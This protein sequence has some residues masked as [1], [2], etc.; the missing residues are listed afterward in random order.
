MP[1]KGGGGSYISGEGRKEEPTLG[2]VLFNRRMKLEEET[3]ASEEGRLL[4]EKE[5]KELQKAREARKEAREQLK[6]HEQEL[7][8]SRREVLD[9][10]KED[11]EENK[12]IMKELLLKE[13]E[14]NRGKVDPVVLRRMI[15][16]ERALREQKEQNI[17]EAGKKLEGAIKDLFFLKDAK[18]KQQ[19]VLG[20]KKKTAEQPKEADNPYELPSDDYGKEIVRFETDY[21]NLNTKLVS[22]GSDQQAVLWVWQEWAASF[23][24]VN[25]ALTEV[26]KKVS[27][28]DP[29]ALKL[30]RMALWLFKV[31]HE[32]SAE[33][34]ITKEGVL[35]EGYRL[36]Q[37][38]PDILNALRVRLNEGGLL[39]TGETARTPAQNRARTA[40]AAPSFAGERRGVAWKPAGAVVTTQGKVMENA[41][42]QEKGFQ[43]EKIDHDIFDEWRDVQRK[44]TK[45]QILPLLKKT[46]QRFNVVLAAEPRHAAEWVDEARTLYDQAIDPN[47][48]QR[49]FVRGKVSTVREHRAW[50]LHTFLQSADA[51]LKEQKPIPED[52]T[53][54]KIAPDIAKLSQ[55]ADATGVVN[56]KFAETAKFSDPTAAGAPAAST[57]GNEHT[58]T[59]AT[60]GRADRK[61][62]ESAAFSFWE[63]NQQGDIGKNLK[64][65]IDTIDRLRNKQNSARKALE[66][67]TE[68]KDIQKGFLGRWSAA[69]DAASREALT[70]KQRALFVVLTVAENALREN[71]SIT[72]DAVQNGLSAWGK[73]R[74][75]KQAEP[76]GTTSE[77]AAEFLPEEPAREA[78]TLPVKE[79]YSVGE[80]SV[81][82]EK[83][84]VNQDASYADA[85]ARVIAVFDG[86][87]GH[88]AGEMASSEAKRELQECAAAL[89]GADTVERAH[90]LLRDI[91]IAMNQKV[92]DA[93]LGKRG[94]EKGGTTAT[95][96]KV[97]HEGDKRVAVVGNLG[98]SRAY[99]FRAQTHQLEQITVDDDLLG[100]L[101]IQ[102]TLTPYISDIRRILSQ[103][104]NEDQLT[105]PQKFAE[106][107]ADMPIAR[108]PEGLARL[109]M[110]IKENFNLISPF[111][112]TLHALFDARN[113]I[114]KALNGHDEAPM[115]TTTE[116]A[117]GDFILCTSDGIHDNLTADSMRNVIEEH[118]NES[119]EQIARVLIDHAQECANE[120]YLR[121]KKDDMTVVILK[122]E[123]VKIVKQDDG[124]QSVSTRRESSEPAGAPVEA[125]ALSVSGEQADEIEALPVYKELLTLYNM[126]RDS[127]AARQSLLGEWR[128]AVSAAQVETDRVKALKYILYKINTGAFDT[129]SSEGGGV[130]VRAHDALYH[131]LHDL[132]PDTAARA[133]IKAG[134]QFNVAIIGTE[135]FKKAEI[136]EYN[137]RTIEIRFS[138]AKGVVPRQL[139]IG[140][141]YHISIVQTNQS[142]EQKRGGGT[143]YWHEAEVVGPNLAQGDIFE[144][145]FERPVNPGVYRA[146]A[147]DGLPVFVKRSED[148]DISKKYNVTITSAANFLEDFGAKRQH[149]GVIEVSETFAGASA[150]SARAVG[151]AEVAHAVV[152]VLDLW[153]GLTPEKKAE[154]AADRVLFMQ[155]FPE[156]IVTRGIF[157]RDEETKE[158]Q[159]LPKGN[160]D[161]ESC[162]FLL[163]HFFDLPGE[164]IEKTKFV[165]PG[166]FRPN[167]L[168]VDTGFETT[169]FQVKWFTKD[170]LSEQGLTVPEML[171]Q[172]EED[173]GGAHV[174]IVQDHGPD[175]NRTM[176][177]FK[178]LYDA[179]IDRYGD[180]AIPPEDR[181][182]MK[183]FV[184]FVTHIDNFTAPTGDF[185][186]KKAW[187]ESDKIPFTITLAK[188]N[189]LN[190]GA[191]YQFFKDHPFED[192]FKR[193]SEWAINAP[194]K[195]TNGRYNFRAETAALERYGF[196]AMGR[197]RKDGR[198]EPIMMEQY[199]LIEKGNRYFE[200]LLHNEPEFIVESSRYG[201][202]L[203]VLDGDN[204]PGRLSS[205]MAHGIDGMLE[206]RPGAKSF[207]FNVAPQKDPAEYGTPQIPRE[208]A[209]E[210]GGV[211]VR[212]SIVMQPDWKKQD[213]KAGLN[214]GAFLEKIGVASDTLGVR[215]RARVVEEN[216]GEKPWE[217]VPADADFLALRE[218]LKKEISNVF[219]QGVSTVDPNQK[220]VNG[221]KEEYFLRRFKR[222]EKFINYSI[223]VW[224]SAVHE[225]FNDQIM[226]E[227]TKWLDGYMKVA[228]VDA[229]AGTITESDGMVSDKTQFFE[230]YKA[231]PQIYSSAPRGLWKGAV[232]RWFD[233]V[234]AGE[235]VLAAPT[236]KSEEAV[237]VAPAEPMAAEPVTGGENAPKAVEPAGAP[238][239]EDSAAGMM[240]RGAED[241]AQ[242]A[243]T[244]E[245]ARAI[246]GAEVE[247]DARVAEARAEL[248]RVTERLARARTAKEQ[249]EGIVKGLAG[250]ITGKGSQAEAEYEA[251]LGAYQEVTER[252]I[253]RTLEQ[254]LEWRV[255]L[256]EKM[257]EARLATP[258]KKG[259]GARAVALWKSA[260]E[261]S[262]YNYIDKKGGW[263][264]K[265]GFVW[266]TLKILSKAANLRTATAL[267]LF[268][269]GWIAG[270][271]AVGWTAAGAGAGLSALGSGIG[272][273]EWTR[274][275]YE[276]G[277]GAVLFGKKSASAVA[278][279]KMFK[280]QAEAEAYY[281]T[282]YAGAGRF[283]KLWRG[284]SGQ[285][286]S[287]EGAAA[288]AVW[289]E[290]L[291]KGNIMD[292]RKA[293]A[294][295]MLAFE[296]DAVLHGKKDLGSNAAYQTLVEAYKEAVVEEEQKVGGALEGYFEAQGKGFVEKLDDAIGGEKSALRRR[297]IF[298]AFAGA[299]LGVA[300]L[301]NFDVR[302]Y[303]RGLGNNGKPPGES[304][305]G[306]D[307]LSG[308]ES[309]PLPRTSSV[310]SVGSTPTTRSPFADLIRGEQ[311]ARVWTGVHKV[312]DGK[313]AH[314]VPQKGHRAVIQAVKELLKADPKEFGM[315]THPSDALVE[316]KATAIARKLGFMGHGYSLGFKFDAEHPVGL[317]AKDGQ[318]SVVA[319]DEATLHNLM[320][321]V[322]AGGGV[323]KPDAASPYV[324]GAFPKI[325][326]HAIFVEGQSGHPVDATHVQASAVVGQLGA[327]SGV[328]DTA[329]SAPRGGDIG[330]SPVGGVGARAHVV[331]GAGVP[332]GAGLTAGELAPH[333]GA[334]AGRG[335]VRAG[336]TVGTTRGVGETVQ[337]AR[338]GGSVG[339]RTGGAGGG[340]SYET[341]TGAGGGASYETRTGAGGG[342]S[343][344]GG[345]AD[346]GGGASSET[347]GAE[348]SGGGA[349]IEARPV[350]VRTIAGVDIQMAGTYSSSDM[351]RIR[352]LAQQLADQ[353]SRAM[354]QRALLGGGDAHATLRGILESDIATFKSDTIKTFKDMVLQGRASV[355]DLEEVVEHSPLRLRAGAV[356]REFGASSA[357]LGAPR[358][359]HAGTADVGPTAGGGGET[360]GAFATA[361][362]RIVANPEKHILSVWNA[363]ARA[364]I[365]L[366]LPDAFE[367]EPRFARGE[368]LAVKI[369]TPGGKRFDGVFK[370][371]EGVA[372]VIFKEGA[373]NKDM[374]WKEFV[375][376]Y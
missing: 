25:H 67:I 101:P 157:E 95:V 257:I 186:W 201:K 141:V 1:K 321:A 283:K 317:F 295:R 222:P 338:G 77:T 32:K 347:V 308:E 316:A 125:Q 211:W 354:D 121:S 254:G 370:F 164:Y 91:F 204:V 311:G 348:K 59:Q 99:V 323:M 8:K 346:G 168:N 150:A 356:S 42:S 315:G 344:A 14:R 337:G 249:Y 178:L 120:Q 93:F 226:D 228:Y 262:L 80:L 84:A 207:W 104:Y 284:L 133:E 87:G 309:A 259:L 221:E 253:G 194:A 161:A 15:K 37:V 363:K 208:L 102:N 288:K 31:D 255:K 90:T 267:S 132:K 375:E 330:E 179:L 162:I 372:R 69:K 28:A 264:D 117:P 233:A 238:R 367:V 274:H 276:T 75:A 64:L 72:F 52:T 272:F 237:T 217:T 60:A 350:A 47:M 231:L 173:K 158:A 203:V 70:L 332:A 353:Y 2:E 334:S 236:T 49:E 297:K 137:G 326:A 22:A 106:T 240:R 298:S 61:K 92:S 43:P 365:P 213:L 17:Q 123:A 103:A 266:G 279:E 206:W 325:R 176:S 190:V 312:A 185:D 155:M 229:A 76:L 287:A 277:G 339:G 244:A 329:H 142:K 265:R 7:E 110:L 11:H 341:R 159:L 23:E 48:H 13:I 371:V 139:E 245:D 212:G 153:A 97:V 44:L 36:V 165:R 40:A 296:A 94:R 199:K 333:L 154:L 368:P 189:F 252:V 45:E 184:R 172:K 21:I 366:A 174:V 282:E 230:R 35:R 71:T 136:E 289:L 85:D 109:N 224:V 290:K 345:R 318:I 128:G 171:G 151:G 202:I 56:E 376:K 322:K 96:A 256:V 19:N 293:L 89:H 263:Q 310:S 58:P 51:A 250:F 209:E 227:F 369:L 188:Q 82:K 68:L 319:E 66:F 34:F 358:A 331:R 225:W 294:E 285:G 360:A 246:E 273:N 304:L 12:N 148:L 243:Q 175:A 78:E 18:V 180:D 349:G 39:P 303:V 65:I 16:E 107:F 196:G 135:K 260:G 38:T 355:K 218:K 357:D 149:K 299:T 286:F 167:A 46:I 10:T 124:T 81:K 86:M 79:R 364:A 26:R 108:E 41:E 163:K 63:N 335:A 336:D 342:D 88:A 351:A 302:S 292:K 305:C 271:T 301:A 144:A 232:E 373:E 220:T 116:L 200:Y 127:S 328:A 239:A 242:A 215:L 160:L 192:A 216:I 143:H 278:S 50:A 134:D 4:T 193:P 62:E 275:G 247:E 306:A 54:Y 145:Q 30:R 320:G 9:A 57:S 83:H 191:L 374:P 362:K 300:S 131:R 129:L 156:G 111:P 241:R 281:Q 100:N 219:H 55:S 234:L 27:G 170:E 182:P 119:P 130:E 251:A 223:N 140:R 181:E 112:E 187:G 152:D 340:A 343:G 314:I 313:Y 147:P 146:F 183:N 268:G 235:R 307:A 291:G 74:G 195:L 6:K 5:K 24:E 280:N 33:Q 29:E 118:A 113:Y 324:E 98:D 270:A 115:I 73:E 248:E 359:P 169:G 53:Y 20:K 177:A 3:E 105:D 327:P 197:V 214:L 114:S 261:V 361:A 352:A 258:E 269:G 126:A 122:G 205:A 138:G 210:V 198:Q 166:E